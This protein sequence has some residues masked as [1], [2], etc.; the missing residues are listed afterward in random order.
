MKTEKT[1]DISDKHLLRGRR[2]VLFEGVLTT[3][4][5]CINGAMIGSVFLTKFFLKL[6]ATSLEIGILAA[7]PQLAYIGQFMG[8]YYIEKY[9]NRKNFCITTS[10]IQKML[11]FVIAVI[12]LFLPQIRTHSRIWL[13][14][15]IIFI[16]SLFGALSGSAWVSWMA[17]FIH[18]E[19]RGK[20]FGR[21]NMLAGLVTL[22]IPIAVGKYL[23]V[24][25]DLSNYAFIFSLAALTGLAGSFCLKNVPKVKMETRSDLQF[26]D[27]IKAPLQNYNFRIFL[28]FTIT[29]TLGTTI[30]FPYITVF[31]LR[32]LSASQYNVGILIALSAITNI[33]FT[34]MW[35]HISDRFG[36]RPV[37]VICVLF[38]SF[39]PL[40]YL[41]T[42]ANNYMLV[43]GIIF[44]LAGIFWSGIGLSLFN[45]LLVLSPD[46]GR[47]KFI[48]SFFSFVGIFGVVGPLA[49]GTIMHFFE[50]LSGNI[51]GLSLNSYTILFL[52]STL[53]RILAFSML[54]KV[55][56]HGDISAPAL[57]VQ[58]LSM[59]PYKAFINKVASVSTTTKNNK[60]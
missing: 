44:M 54:L 40:G 19:T 25:N 23:D 18:P 47:S 2:A 49:G 39:L 17:D 6:G 33:I 5:V 34:P 50:S 45:L 10:F 31:L 26:V 4:F 58:F 29:W 9:G 20:F 56:V 48:S 51:L 3:T 11:W 43:V 36:H 8:S 30:L 14:F 7:L 60:K 22:C 59:N 55:K 16:S 52:L 13:L 32:E 38:S 12:P 35:G 53:L 57:V 41:V 27:I 1:N 28:Y 37:L 15:A 24:H 46:K 21:R 42:T